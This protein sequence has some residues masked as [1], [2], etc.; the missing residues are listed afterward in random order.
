MLDYAKRIEDQILGSSEGF[1]DDLEVRKDLCVT[2]RIAESFYGFLERYGEAPSESEISYMT[3]TIRSGIDNFFSLAYICKVINTEQET[4]AF[5]THAQW[6]YPA[7]RTKFLHGF[8]HLAADATPSAAEKLATLFALTH[9]ELVFLAQHFP[10][11]IL[12]RKISY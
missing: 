9:L 2:I 5:A 12:G 10:S 4:W 7:L 8:Q 3:D 6:D 11:A 1:F